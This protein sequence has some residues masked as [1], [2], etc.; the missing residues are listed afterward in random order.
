MSAQPIEAPPHFTY[1]ATS[2]NRLAVQ[3]VID[4]LALPAPT[5]VARADVVHVCVADVDDLG[6]WLYELGGEVRRG[7]AL[8]GVSVWTL[9]TQTPMRRNG[10][11]VAIRV[12]CPVVTGE[13]VIADIYAAVTE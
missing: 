8:D 2:D 1:A 7:I 3:T 13:D 6:R 9:R 10:A 4:G 5:L 11:P 12:H